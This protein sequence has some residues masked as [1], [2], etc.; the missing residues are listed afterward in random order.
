MIEENIFGPQIGKVHDQLEKKKKVNC[1]S[2][3]LKKNL[4]FMDAI[5]IE[6]E[7][8]DWKK[9]FAILIPDK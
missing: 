1:A 3:K 9:I 6:K 8:T 4:I 7:S 2:N 5:R